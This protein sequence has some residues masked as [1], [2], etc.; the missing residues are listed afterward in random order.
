VTLAA[1]GSAGV[2]VGAVGAFGLSHG[3]YAPTPPSDPASSRT[4]PLAPHQPG[5]VS[6]NPAPKAITLRA[7]DLPAGSRLLREA[8]VGF[9]PTDARGGP[10]SWD[11]IF[12][13]G[14]GQMIE[15]LAVVYP[16]ADAARAAF[17]AQDVAEQ[18]AGAVRQS[19]IRGLGDRESVWQETGP[20]GA[21]GITRVTWQSLNVVAQV[22]VLG[23]AGGVSQ[24]GVLNL[25]AVEQ[26]RIAA[27]APASAGDA[28][29]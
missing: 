16:D 1:L 18:A 5:E 19:P 15:S 20:S 11:A 17:D 6:R 7:S 14:D 25:A 9:S 26:D 3:W 27:P 28:G 23:P 8:P 21:Q 12:V 13:S 22:S 24:D 4:A 29:S 10:S 2:A